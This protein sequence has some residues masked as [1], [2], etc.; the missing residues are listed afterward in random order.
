MKMV[1]A[2]VQAEDVS[3]VTTA[4]VDAGR[5]VVARLDRTVTLNCDYRMRG[6][7]R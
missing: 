1:M 6:Y 2:I 7:S 3:S 4:L 5:A